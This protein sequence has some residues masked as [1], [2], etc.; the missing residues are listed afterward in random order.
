MKQISKVTRKK[1]NPHIVET[2]KLMNDE[3][4]RYIGYMMKTKYHDIPWWYNERAL[5]GF[6]AAGLA[7]HKD[8]LVFQE[9]TC[10]KGKASK[11]EKSHGRA[12]LLFRYKEHN[13][14]AEAKLYF[15]PI[16]TK[17]D[18]KDAVSWAAE[19]FQQAQSYHKK[20]FPFKADYILSLC[21]EVIYCHENKIEEMQE[22]LKGWRDTTWVKPA[23]FYCA[24][25]EL[26]LNNKEIK[27][28]WQADNGATYYYPALAV[29]GKIKKI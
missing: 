1:G 11:K 13:Y 25:I 20:D 4:N 16:D 2:I 21:F 29:Y 6:F 23:S 14:I 8:A 12:D 24:L 17:T 22:L 27:Y 7:R 28:D 5:L 19:V 10:S 15:S 9:F 18:Y 3:F 26:D